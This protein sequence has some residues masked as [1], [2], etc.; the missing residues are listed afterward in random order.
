MAR[1]PGDFFLRVYQAHGPIF[2]IK[3][4]NRVHTL[5]AGPETN[6]FVSGYGN[7]FFRSKFNRRA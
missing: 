7:E 6:I 2:R 4:L 1:D 5:L 3:I